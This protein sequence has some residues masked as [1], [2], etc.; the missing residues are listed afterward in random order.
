MAEETTGAL[1]QGFRQAMQNFLAP[2]LREMRANTQRLED[3]RTE[4]REWRTAMD[5]RF[6]RIEHQLDTY[7]DVQTLKEQ[8]AELRAR[9]QPSA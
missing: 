7:Q 2:E 6:E 1:I 9:Q 4:L 8:M 5:R 3:L